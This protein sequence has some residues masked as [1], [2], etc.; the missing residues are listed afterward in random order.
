MTGY[1]FREV[2]KWSFIAAV[3]AALWC[4]VMTV[5]KA[6]AA[7]A[8]QSEMSFI[9]MDRKPSDDVRPIWVIVVF[10]VQSEKLIGITELVLESYGECQLTS[11]EVK[12][13]LGLRLKR[14][15]YLRWMKGDRVSKGTVM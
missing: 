4:G 7:I 6:R 10:E 14:V 11:A 15:C 2:L 12:K 3:I 1:D 8:A 5:G 9:Q 13:K